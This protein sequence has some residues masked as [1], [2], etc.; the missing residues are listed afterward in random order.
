MPGA[1][2]PDMNDDAVP[3]DPANADTL[4]AWDGG[5]GEYWAE[6]ADRFEAS[7]ARYRDA[8]FDAAAITAT[9]VVLDIGCGSGA[10]TRE[11]AQRAPRGSALGIDLSTP[12]LDLAARRAR[13]EGVD[14]VRFVHGD[15]QVYPFAADAF[16][17]AISRSGAMFFADPVVAFT[18]VAR[19]LESGGRLM[20]MVWQSVDRN[21]WVRDFSAIL[22]AG[23]DTPAPPPGTPGPFSLADTDRT[24]ALLSA[25]GFRD[26]EFA[27]VVEPMWFGATTDDAYRFIS[28]MGFTQF[29]LKELDEAARARALDD[30]RSNI[31]A[32]ISAD[33]VRYDS[34]A[35]HVSARRA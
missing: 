3:V 1:S 13:E 16:T 22:A 11:A 34:A 10:T 33:G 27:D 19:A 28:G 8:F 5:E 12:M 17:V 9:D 2:E 20:L 21:D 6:N 24:Q 14:N 29:M 23:R 25:A 18:N 32:H 4:A 26:V 35:W 31:D 7:V 15:A 30:L